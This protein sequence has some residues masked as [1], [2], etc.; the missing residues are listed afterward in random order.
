MCVEYD[1]KTNF[2][3]ETNCS[4]YTL[5]EAI[6]NRTKCLNLP[7]PENADVL[8]KSWVFDWL[9]NIP[10]YVFVILGILGFVFVLAFVMLVVQLVCINFYKM[11]YHIE[12]PIFEI[13]IS[14]A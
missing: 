13:S 11:C 4:S 6:E 1:L 3:L 2:V 14:F 10:S 8:E 5:D 7:D 9:K 12:L